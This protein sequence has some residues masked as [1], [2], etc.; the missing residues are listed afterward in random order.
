MLWK[1]ASF[2][3]K[4]VWAHVNE[5]DEVELANGLVKIRYSTKEGATIYRASSKNIQLSSDPSKP[6]DEG[7][8]APKLDGS[9]ATKPKVRKKF[10]S[11]NTRTEEQ[12]TAARKDTQ[13]FLKGLSDNTIRC[14]TDG[15]CI[16]NP[17]PCGTGVYIQ[18]PDKEIKHYRYLGEGTNN[19][20][21]LSAV[22][23]A[24]QLLD[25]EGVDKDTPVVVCT[26]STYVVGILTKNWKA[27]ANKD[28]IFPLRAEAK[29]WSNLIIR[30]VAGHADIP[31]NDEA[32][33]L[34]NLAISEGRA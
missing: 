31:E 28:I 1:P 5:A 34:A 3:G 19:K 8:N 33:R 10:G 2:K 17:G 13:Q 20:A 12:K 15:S 27:K 24:M 22:L 32:D 16:G 11:A 23:D 6:L 30:W 14:F 29:K 21:E 7:S 18:L 26:D 9:K 4:K 25:A